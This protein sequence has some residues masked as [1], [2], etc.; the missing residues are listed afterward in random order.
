MNC[1][2]KEE[3]NILNLFKIYDCETCASLKED[4]IIKIGKRVIGIY[5]FEKCNLDK[6]LLQA[7]FLAFLLEAI[8]NNDSIILLWGEEHI[9]AQ[10]YEA[11]DAFLE[12][13]MDIQII[14]Y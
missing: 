8:K 7:K 1:S 14:N 13:G 4:E 3:R 10:Y 12:S 5:K 11:L 2:K 6:S 9:K